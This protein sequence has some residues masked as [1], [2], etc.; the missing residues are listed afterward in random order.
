[1]GTSNTNAIDSLWKG[2]YRVG[3]AAALLAGVVFRRNL[4][5]EV[6]LFGPQAPASVAGWFALLQENRLLGLTLL[7][8]FDVVDYALVGLML[9]ALCVALWRT[10]RSASAIAT[11]CGLV[12][13]A[14]SFASNAAFAMLSLSDQYAAAASEAERSMLLAAGQ[15]LLAAGEGGGFYLSILLLAVAGLIFSALM[16]RSGAFGRAAAWVGLQIGRAHV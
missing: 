2:L 13:I 11:A 7:S 8:I 10:G 3:G 9:V 4:G 5:V 15:A 1:M 16:L 12:G 6:S 14:V